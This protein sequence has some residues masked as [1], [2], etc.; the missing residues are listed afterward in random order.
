MRK[1]K[2]AS[3]IKL[4]SLPVNMPED[5]DKESPKQVTFNFTVVDMRRIFHSFSTAKP[6]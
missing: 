6:I 3:L 5:K 1:R 2:V 4:F